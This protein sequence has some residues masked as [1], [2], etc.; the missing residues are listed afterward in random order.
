MSRL[1]YRTL[2][3]ILSFLLI[4]LILLIQANRKAGVVSAGWFDDGWHYRKAVNIT[5]SV[6]TTLTD[7][8]VSIS[9]GTSALI[10]SGKM[11]SDCDDIRITDV[12]GKLL[13]HWIEENN[14]GCNATTDTKVWVKAPSIP[15]SGGTV[16]IYYGNP[17]ATNVASGDK[18][19]EFFDDFSKDLSKW[20]NVSSSA[21]SISSGILN[22]TPP[23]ND[24]YLVANKSV[25]ASGIVIETRM[26]SNHTTGTGHPGVLWHANTSLGTSHQNDHLYVRPH[27]YNTTNNVQPAYY[28][29]SL[30]TFGNVTGL[31]NYN[32]WY[33]IKIEIINSNSIKYYRNDTNE[34]NFASQQYQSNTYAGIVAHGSNNQQWDNFRIRKYASTD[35]TSSLSSTEEVGKA[36]VA[37]WKFDEGVGTTA[38]DS[39]SSKNIGT[40][41][42]GT[43]W[44]K[45]ESC[46]SGKCIKMDGSNDYASAS[47]S[48]SLDGNEN[49][50]TMSMWFKSNN[51][52][53][54][55]TFLIKKETPGYD[56]G[57]NTAGKLFITI[58]HLYDTTW[59][60]SP[61]TSDSALESNKWYHVETTFIKNGSLKIYIDG[62]LNKSC[63]PAYSYG[64]GS[65]NNPFYIGIQ[66]WQASGN[67]TFDGF[68]DD[69]K[70]YPYARTAA[71]IKSDY[72]SGLAGMG[73]NEGSSVNIGGD[74]TNLSDG[75]VGYW[76]MDEGVG[77]TTLDKSGNN[78]TGTFGTGSSAPA[79]STGKFGVGTSYDGND[80]VNAGNFGTL[81]PQGTISYWMKPSV[82]ENYRN[83]LSTKYLGGNSCFRFEEYTTISPYG[84][85]S[86]IIG[87]DGGTYTSHSYLTSNTLQ[88]NTWYHVVLVWDSVT[89]MATGY[90]DGQQK[91]NEAH[92]YWPTTLPSIT[93]GGGFDVN[94]YWKGLI[95]EV[96]I[97]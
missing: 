59:R 85:F 25:G 87:N 22:I 62:K 16:Y 63:A 3:I 17:S 18:V 27:S 44:E 31:Y 90:L 82:V 78:N 81:T 57:L 21:W 19:F 84:G 6:G 29:G 39:T 37:Y 45:E 36:P 69:V 88:V 95:D 13:N 92:T 34:A 97:Y 93:I 96:R 43:V 28:N 1:S 61:C 14:P 53:A 24:N 56:M 23:A 20:L 52:T 8:Q 49:E 66:G 64:M 10:A 30:N 74:N 2:L 15:S 50:I 58:F 51:I 86:T 48:T 73:T 80:Y 54:G 42:N 41:V 71:E 76:T 83:P 40:L 77:T 79:W 89:N 91:F 67:V 35:P 47:D 46:I 65:N 55:N 38:Y 9:I 33:N 7:F 60:Y 32:T 11:Q 12:N 94:R 68:I 72:A 4:P 5:N 75:L 26:K 70:I